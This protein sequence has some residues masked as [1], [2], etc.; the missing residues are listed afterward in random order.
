MED[1]EKSYFL[2]KNPL[3]STKKTRIHKCLLGISHQ[4]V[5]KYIHSLV[6]K[7]SPTGRGLACMTE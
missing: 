3:Y 2:T 1:L 4:A 6:A 7:T 5:V